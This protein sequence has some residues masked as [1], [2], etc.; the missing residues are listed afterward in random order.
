M[1]IIYQKLK[2]PRIDANRVCPLHRAASKHRS[3][4]KLAALGLRV[5]VELLSLVASLAPTCCISGIHQST[6]EGQKISP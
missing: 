1:F 4:L 3:R 2:L 6:E 5:S